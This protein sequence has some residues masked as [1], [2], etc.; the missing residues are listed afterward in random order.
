M[1]SN[2][3]KEEGAAEGKLRFKWEGSLGRKYGTWKEVGAEVEP[4][5]AKNLG[6]VQSTADPFSG[7]TSDPV[8]A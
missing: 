6:W 7:I 4:F 2:K 8:T 1:K 3:W 5:L